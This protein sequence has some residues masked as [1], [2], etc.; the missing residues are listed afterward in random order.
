MKNC[1]HFKSVL[2]SGYDAVRIYLEKSARIDLNQE[3]CPYCKNTGCTR[4]GYY[5]HQC[6]DFVNGAVIIRHFRMLRAKCKECGH[7][8]AV[9]CGIFAAYCRYSLALIREICT[10]S[11][12][13]AFSIKTICDSLSL[14]PRT[15]SRWK[16]LSSGNAAAFSR[17]LVAQNSQSGTKPQSPSYERGLPPGMITAWGGYTHELH[18]SCY[19]FIVLQ[20]PGQRVSGHP[21]SGRVC[22]LCPSGRKEPPVQDYTVIIG[23][24]KLRGQNVPYRTIGARYG[25]WA[26]AIE[27]IL[28]RYKSCG[29]TLEELS[30]M[31]PSEVENIFYPASI[32]SWKKSPDPDFEAIHRRM[33]EMGKN[34]DLSLIWLE[35]HRDN[36]SGYMLSRFYQLYNK[37]CKD[38][39]GEAGRVKMPVE[40][41]PGKNIYI[42]WAGDKP[43]LVDGPDGGLVKCHIFITTVGLSSLLFGEMFPDEKTPQFIA[44]VVD[45]L[46]SYGAVPE[47][48][49]PD[50]LKTAVTT[51]TKDRLELNAVF[52]DLESFYDVVVLP[53]P[54]R[55]PKGKPSVENGVKTVEKK[56]VEQLREKAPYRSFREANEELSRLIREQNDSTLH[57]QM[58]RT[59]IFENYDRPAMKKFSNYGRF[60]NCDYKYVQRLADNYHIFY[61]GHYYSVPYRYVGKSLVL[62]ASG[63]EIVVCDRD[64][65]FICRHERSYREFPKYVTEDSHMPAEHRYYKELGIRD[66]AYYRGW[67]AH[68]G[69]YMV[70]MINRI[71]ASAKHEEQMYRSCNG[72][73]HMCDD[74]P[75]GTVEEA[76][77]QCVEASA[78][79]YSYFKKILKGMKPGMNDVPAA[80]PPEN[81]NIRGK[82]AYR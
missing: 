68:Y 20:K 27:L 23:V 79:S 51:H 37:Y 30:V 77:R 43:E 67:A 40:R 35:Y 75:H 31:A 25:I 45:A 16:A 52:S 41:I 13:S 38:H 6:R 24:L 47:I 61:D 14:C 29:H 53:P 1:I 22:E 82:D 48:L 7:T 36:P 39:F 57:R 63:T 72:I 10:A 65:R 19:T 9:R 73:L 17:P 66:G 8:H 62:K 4:H 64:N 3:T 74:M 58:S 71:L 2:D 18:I 78:C 50:N 15:V 69:K 56:L 55:K 32:R 80:V 11:Q 28:R 70:Q 33:T 12:K 76:A 44:G 81:T 34:A 21:H 59:Q 5:Q 54:P 46:E 49:V 42:D 60:S 26:N